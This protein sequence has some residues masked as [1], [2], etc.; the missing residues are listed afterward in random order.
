MESL[1]ST[2]VEQ[3]VSASTRADEAKESGQDVGMI[4]M[5]I[6]SLRQTLASIGQR[7]NLAEVGAKGF[8]LMTDHSEEPS[9][10]YAGRTVPISTSYLRSL[11]SEAGV[12]LRPYQIILLDRGLV[13]DLVEEALAANAQE[14]MR[15][16]FRKSLLRDVALATYAETRLSETPAERSPSGRTGAAA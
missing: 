9:V 3:L 4:K 1:V 6:R 12:D 10:R 11:L 15:V 7:R 16:R 8:V 2:L 13:R 5:I 14:D